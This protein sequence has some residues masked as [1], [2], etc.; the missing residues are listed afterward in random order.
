MKFLLALLLLP[1]LVCAVG[2]DEPT[3]IERPAQARALMVQ[4]IPGLSA[5]TYENLVRYAFD[6]EEGKVNAQ[7]LQLVIHAAQW[8]VYRKRQA[9]LALNAQREAREA[10]VRADAEAAG[11]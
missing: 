11:R 9:L 6:P 4:Q 7:D 10:M 2:Q 8:Q 1:T 5:Q 3:F